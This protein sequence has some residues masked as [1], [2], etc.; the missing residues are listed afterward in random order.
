MTCKAMIT[1]MHIEEK[2]REHNEVV[3]VYCILHESTQ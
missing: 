3:Y 1:Q 2:I